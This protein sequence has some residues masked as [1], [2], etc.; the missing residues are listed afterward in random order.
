[1]FKGELGGKISRIDQNREKFLKMEIARKNYLNEF[2]RLQQKCCNPKVTE[3]KKEK[4]IYRS[5]DLAI[6][7][8]PQLEQKIIDSWRR[9]WI[10]A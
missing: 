3:G 10:Q 7:V 9:E 1:M 6:R 5:V 2:E 4:I 8:L